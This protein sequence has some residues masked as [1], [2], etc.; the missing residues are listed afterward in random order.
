MT[1]KLSCPHC[2]LVRDV[3]LIERD[4]TVSIKGRDVVFKAQRYRCMT[5]GD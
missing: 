2:E 5:C 3:E 4:E 1:E